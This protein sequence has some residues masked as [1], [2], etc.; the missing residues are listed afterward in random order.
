[1]QPTPRDLIDIVDAISK[2]L[3]A[4]RLR[5]THSSSLSTGRGLVGPAGQG[6]VQTLMLLDGTSNT[7]LLHGVLAACVATQARRSSDSV[8]Q[9][10]VIARLDQEAGHPVNDHL[11]Q[12]SNPICDESSDGG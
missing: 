3:V 10:T 11:R 1:V 8:H 4:Y 6:L 2:L 9:A 7:Q 5:I 12:T